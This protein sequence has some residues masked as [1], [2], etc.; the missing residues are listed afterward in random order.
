MLHSDQGV[1]PLKNHDT[2][3][4]VVTQAQD[5]NAETV[6]GLLEIPEKSTSSKMEIIYHEE[7][8]GSLKPTKFDKYFVT[9]GTQLNDYNIQ[10]WTWPLCMFD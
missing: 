6:R 9:T 3:Q 10:D 5:E 8:I 1:Y 4:G 2:V 7:L